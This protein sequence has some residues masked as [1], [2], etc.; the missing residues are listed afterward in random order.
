MK[1][2]NIQLKQNYVVW[3]E[4]GK[5]EE[6]VPYPRNYEKLPR[7]SKL[8]RMHIERSQEKFVTLF[9]FE[10]KPVHLAVK[11]SNPNA[12]DDLY[13]AITL[14]SHFELASFFLYLT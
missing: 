12:A 10:D 11:L 14:R 9:A 8:Q 7:L 13:K 6:L 5:K 3:I 2:P 1:L 4:H